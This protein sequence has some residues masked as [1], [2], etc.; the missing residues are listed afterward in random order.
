MFRRLYI[1]I[2]LPLLSSVVCQ[3][4]TSSERSYAQNF[5][6]ENFKTHRILTIRNTH[7]GAATTTQ[8]ALIPKTSQLPDLPPDLTV[9]RTP[10]ERVVIMETVYIGYLEALDQLD[11]IVGAGTVN[12]ISNSAVRAR[13]ESN[14]IQSVQVGQSLD[15][16]R[17]LVLQPD[18]ILTSISGDPAFDIP[19]KLSRSGLPVVLTA[20]YME[21]HPLARAEWIKYIAAFF[22]AE[23]TADVHFQQ[24]ANHYEALKAKVCNIANKPTVFVGAPYSGVWHVAAGESYTARAIRD[25]GGDYLW[26]DLSQQ[27]AIPLDIERVFLRAANADIWLNPS[28]FRS[29]DELLTAETRFVNFKAAQ[30]GAVFNNTKQVASNGGN[31]IWETGIVRP[32]K[33]LADMIA[34]FHPEHMPDHAFVF[35]EPLK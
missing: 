7:Q 12:F 27:G 10:V 8:Y 32:D 2:L 30:I 4:Q 28:F 18:L 19:A 9:I 22:D 13:V 35:Y 17:M 26:S 31:A 15:I 3:A 33:V 5:E 24:V 25:A 29:L 21:A 34:I 16:E 20:G 11:T 23:T 1:L 14:D 6:I